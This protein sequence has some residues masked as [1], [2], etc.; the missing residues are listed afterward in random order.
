MRE[1]LGATYSPSAVSYAQRTFAG[2]GHITAYA[3]VP[4]ET[5]H[6]TATAIRA[7][8]AELAD[9]PVDSDLLDRARNPIREAFQ[10]AESGN[11]GWIELVA[12]AQS[13]PEVLTRRRVRREILDALTPA[14]LQA[15]AK[16]YMTGETPLE[17]RVVPQG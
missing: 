15:V 10:R 17:I 5:M 13:D 7:I 4:A 11:S 1:E 9:A 3:T 2:F 8:A 14:D 6:E 16:R 12:M